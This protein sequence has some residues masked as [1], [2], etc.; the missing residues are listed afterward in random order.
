MLTSSDL[1][2]GLR[3]NPIWARFITTVASTGM[4]REDGHNPPSPVVV[5]R[6][7][8]TVSSPKHGSGCG[9]A[10]LLAS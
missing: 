6:S 5:A 3:R 10:R 9:M 4:F 2:S 8:T 1:G 7:D